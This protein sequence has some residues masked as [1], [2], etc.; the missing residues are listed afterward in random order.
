MSLTLFIVLTLFILGICVGSFLNVLIYRTLRGESPAD[1]RSRCRECKKTIAWYDNIPLLSF[2]LLRGK[3]RS[4]QTSISWQYPVVELLTGV[5][6]VWW[7]AVGF[8]FFQLTQSPLL[9]LQPVFW[10]LVGILLLII[11]VTD[12]LEY[13]IP[14]YAVIGLAILAVS[15]RLYLG[16]TGAMQWVDVAA[17]LISGVVMAVFFLVLFLV[18]RGK[19]LGF[20][21]VKY[22]LVMGWLLGWPRVLVG[23]F[24]AFVVGAVVGLVLIGLGRKKMKQM[25]PFGPFLVL[26][27]VVGLVYGM[28]IWGWYWGLIR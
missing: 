14:D 7:Y 12:Y 21:D 11:L 27:T 6:F 5:L 3:C 19:G 15:Y 26:G 16:Y 2:V 4:C 22:V 28:D 18:T 24:V 8:A 1:G 9:Y 17:A 13:I 20:G 25:V 10:L 23:V